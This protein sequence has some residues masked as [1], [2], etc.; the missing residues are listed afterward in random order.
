MSPEKAVGWEL[1][2]SAWVTLQQGKPTHSLQSPEKGREGLAPPAGLQAPPLKGKL[3][4]SPAWS[5]IPPLGA[6]PKEEERK[7]L[8]RDFQ[9]VRL[10]EDIT[11]EQD[12]ELCLQLR[13]W[14]ESV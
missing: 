7:T 1:E 5:K 6:F 4:I 3:Q 12:R 10:L 11:W 8:I 2:L 13:S 14:N 9:S